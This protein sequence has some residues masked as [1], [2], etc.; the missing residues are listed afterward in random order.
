MSKTDTMFRRHGVDNSQ[1]IDIIDI[2]LLM[3]F[4]PLQSRKLKFVKYLDN[5]GADVKQIEK[6]FV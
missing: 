5:A 3:H 6:Y 2:A 4:Q 1:C